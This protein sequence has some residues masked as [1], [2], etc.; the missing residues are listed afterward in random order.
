MVFF[1]LSLSLSLAH[2]A[3]SFF[4]HIVAAN[5]CGS[6]VTLCLDSLPPPLMIVLLHPTS[7]FPNKKCF[8]SVP[9]SL[10][11]TRN[12]PPPLPSDDS[13]LSAPVTSKA[14][15]GEKELLLR[16]LRLLIHYH[17]AHPKML[18]LFFACLLLSRGGGFFELQ[19]C[20]FSAGKNLNSNKAADEMPKPLLS[21]PAHNALS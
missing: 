12:L 15:K 6:P 2:Y 18:L 21:S 4:W 5:Y 11:Q 19:L 3:I 8:S 17:H 7:D 20:C 16:L 1:P 13:S 10:T 9:V 14:R